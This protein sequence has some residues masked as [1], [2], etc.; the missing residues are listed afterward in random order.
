MWDTLKKLFGK[1]QPQ[2][3]A[4]KGAV[5]DHGNALSVAIE[6]DRCGEH[7]MVRLRKSSDIQRNYE[8]GDFAFF[9]Q[10]TV[11][12]TSCFNR[13]E[14]RLEF[15]ARYRL[16]SSKIRGGTLATNQKPQ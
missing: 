11:V 10:K 16:I 8:V 2:V 7:I 9:V 5:R 1:G 14:M 3:Y 15:D 12:G 6:C 4:H 13:I